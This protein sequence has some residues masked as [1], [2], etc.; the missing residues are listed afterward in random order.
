MILFWILDTNEW[1]LFDS[2]PVDYFLQGVVGACGISVL[3]SLLRVYNL[4]QT[5]S[6]SQGETESKRRLSTAAGPQKGSWR[7]TLHFWCLAVLLSL[8]GSRVSSLVVLEFSLRVVFAC[9][10]EGLDGSS[11]G[12]DLL[13][14]QSQFSLGCSLTCTLAFLH[15]GAPHS[16]L[17]LL[18]AAALSR[19][20][21]GLCHGLWSHAVRL[22]PLHSTERYCGKC[23]TLQ[24]SGHGILGSLQRAVILAFAV[25]AVAATSTVYEHFLSQKDAVKFWTPLTL[26]YYSMLVF[27]IQEDQHRQPGAEALLHTVVVRLGG[28]LVL[29]LTLGSW[30]DVLHVLVAFVGEGVCML[31]S[32]DLLQAAL[33]EHEQTRLIRHESSSHR[34]RLRKSADS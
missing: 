17:G 33:K 26:C 16:S 27:Y 32:Q 2:N 9:A 23:I 18:L 7:A 3:R 34:R 5:C 8:V 20:L 29:M 6:D 4:I 30:S 24:T 13:L 12:L 21:A 14:I 11:R 31:P 19:A 1:M 22:Y 10:S 25:A 28:L 15:Q